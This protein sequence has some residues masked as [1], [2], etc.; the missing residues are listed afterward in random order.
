MR[1]LHGLEPW[2]AIPDF[3]DAAWSRYVDLAHSIRHVE[4]AVVSAVLDAFVA[5]V[6]TEEYRGYESESKPFLLLRVLFELPESAPAS[7]RSIFK[8]WTNWPE[9]DQ[10]GRVSLSWPVS[11]RSGRP[12]LIANYEGSEGR[13]YDAVNEYRLFLRT[14][15]HRDLGIA[16]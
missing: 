7:D 14:Y 8:G 12:R 6:S 3:S 2:R 16:P 1:L 4:Q 5:E 11:W 13:P 9:P 10:A 15:P